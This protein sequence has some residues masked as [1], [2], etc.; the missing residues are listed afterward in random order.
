MYLIVV[1]YIQFI[2]HNVVLVV[3]VIEIDDTQPSER[4]RN[5][6]FVEQMP[7]R[8]AKVVRSTIQDEAITCPV[9]LVVPSAY[10]LVVAQEQISVLTDHSHPQEPIH[11]YDKLRLFHFLFKLLSIPHT[12]EV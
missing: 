6:E 12:S 10:A 11:S 8:P 1:F 7:S 2:T 5:L 4:G 9:E 3:V